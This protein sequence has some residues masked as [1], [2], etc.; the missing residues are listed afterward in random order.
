MVVTVRSIRLCCSPLAPSFKL[1]LDAVR[2]RTYI[3][4]ILTTDVN[5]LISR[6]YYYRV[7]NG[8]SDP[9]KI[10]VILYY[11]KRRLNKGL[12]KVICC[13]KSELTMEVVGW[14][15]VSLEMY[16]CFENRPKITPNQY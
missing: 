11:S 15:Q 3:H 2:L 6:P 5:L 13:Q 10:A 7:I 1:T 12:C 8:F 14:V 16:V 4:K 9:P